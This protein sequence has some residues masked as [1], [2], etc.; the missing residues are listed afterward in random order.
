[1]HL[2]NPQADGKLS[3]RV[4]GKLAKNFVEEIAYGAYHVAVL[5]LK[6]EIYPWGK[7]E[8]GQLGHG[9]TDDRNSPFLVEFLED[10]QVKSVACGACFTAVICLHRSVSTVDQSKCSSFQLLFNSKRKCHN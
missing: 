8:N 2:W 7:G 1:M 6:T 10:K 4:E 9:D 3:I 5:T